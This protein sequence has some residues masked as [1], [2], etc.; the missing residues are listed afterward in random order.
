MKN[1]IEWSDRTRLIDLKNRFCTLYKNDDGTMF[2]IEPLYYQGLQYYK[3]LAPKKYQDILDEM[4]RQVK[5]NKLVVFVGDEDEPMTI[6]DD[7]VKAI[8]LTIQDITERINLTNEPKRYK[9]DYTD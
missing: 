6:I 3:G 7:G 4:D 2:Y 9:T 8:Y 1:Y 5:N